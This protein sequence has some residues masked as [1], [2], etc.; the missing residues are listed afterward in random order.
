MV[1]VLISLEVGRALEVLATL[2][3]G[4]ALE[5]EVDASVEVRATKLDGEELAPRAMLCVASGTE[6]VLAT[7]VAEVPVETAAEGDEESIW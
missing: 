7:G 2:E 3:V 5:L 1:E 6:L 4:A